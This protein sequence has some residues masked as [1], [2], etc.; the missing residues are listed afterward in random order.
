MLLPNS[1]DEHARI[2]DDH[3]IDVGMFQLHARVERRRHV[4]RAHR[5]LAGGPEVVDLRAKAGG[6]GDEFRGWGE[7]LR[8]KIG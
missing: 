3:A 8:D 2:E 7:C 1:V 5:H 6:R 4:G